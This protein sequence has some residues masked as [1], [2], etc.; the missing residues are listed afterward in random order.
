IAWPAF[1]VLVVTGLW[2]LGQTHVGDQSSAWIATLFAKLVVVAEPRFVGRGG[3]VRPGC[4]RRGRPRP[5]PGRGRDRR[6]EPLPGRPGR[7]RRRARPPAGRARTPG[8]GRP[9]RD[10]G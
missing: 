1:A 3:S 7:P 10:G 6:R 9:A 4:R 2:N 8:P 5:G